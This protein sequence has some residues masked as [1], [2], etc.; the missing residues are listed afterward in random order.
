MQLHHGDCLDVLP[1][2]ADDSIG[3]VIADPPYSLSSASSRRSSN[4]AMGW[5]DINNASVWFSLW[6][7]ECW[8]VLKDSGCF[9]TFCSWQSLPVV[10]CAAS[11]VPGMH[12]TSVLVWNKDWPGVGSTAG[13]R[14]YYELV[15]LIRKPNFYIQDR[16]I[17]DI[18]TEKWT[19][20]KPHGVAAE[21][22]VPLIER[23]ITVC[24]LWNGDTILDPFMGSGTTGE[25]C[26]KTGLDFIGIELD[27]GCFAIAQQRIE[28][29]QNEVV[30]GELAMV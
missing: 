8:R 27:S 7:S 24:E 25:A 1:T 21:K 20:H 12:L 22:P 4:K 14:Q 15:V 19:S 13:L 29:A 3:A 28:A 2:I 16:T 18:W 26:I 30:Q 9:W 17:G 23:I 6:Y 5:A 11:R 10:Q